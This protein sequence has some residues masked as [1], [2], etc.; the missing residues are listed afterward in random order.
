VTQTHSLTLIEYTKSSVLGLL[1]VADPLH[2]KLVCWLRGVDGG[3]FD[4]SPTELIFWSGQNLGAVDLTS[5]K[6]VRVAR[7][8]APPF[9]VTTSPDGRAIA[10]RTIDA[11]GAISTHVYSSGV[12]QVLHT[13][14]PVGGHGGPQW[15]PVDVL[16]F[17]ADGTLLVDYSLFRPNPPGPA[18][19]LV[20]SVQDV[21]TANGGQQPK[22]VLEVAN[23]LE[24]LWAPAGA[25]LYYLQ[26]NPDGQHMT[27][28]QA[29]P[30]QT[31]P[32][33]VIT[34]LPSVVPWPSMIPDG[35][36]LVYDA[37]V[38]TGPGD[39]C[40]G[41]PHLFRADFANVR[42]TQLVSAVSSHSFFVTPTV[43]WSNAEVPSA[44]GMGGESTENG[45]ILAYDLATGI[46][47]AV[48]MSVAIP[49]IG[50][51][52]NS[53]SELVGVWF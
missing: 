13:Q 37:N 12:D 35:S 25:T 14:Q 50:G 41:L 10:Y 19:L 21:L 34:N 22:P 33:P 18:G 42:S 31:A 39:T 43:I 9:D 11:A 28:Y 29:V 8:A 17:S 47:S 20:F 23:G 38:L 32:Q 1:D 4:Q 48:D 6:V 3:A 53:T 16:R 45:I 2:P 52:Q 15:G 7:L 5:K 24:P 27:V 46:T 40:G 44:C 26:E 49:G 30:G 51:P 36:G